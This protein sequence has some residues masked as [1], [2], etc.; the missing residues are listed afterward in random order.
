[1]IIHD[2]LRRG[3]LVIQQHP[4]AEDLIVTRCVFLTGPDE[5][6]VDMRHYSFFGRFLFTSPPDAL[7]TNCIFQGLEI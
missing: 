5:Y 2:E 7:I 3:G 4:L 6:A 1:M